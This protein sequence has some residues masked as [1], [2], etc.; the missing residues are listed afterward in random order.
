[1]RIHQWYKNLVIYL[2]LI[3]SNSLFNKELF[4][5]TTLGLI[6]LCLISST[7][8]IINDIL[9]RKKDKEHQ[10]KKTRPIAYGSIKIYEAIIIALIIT[11]ISLFIA[12]NLSKIFLLSVIF[13]LVLTLL[14]SFKLKHIL[15]LDIIIIS[16]NF[17]IRSVSGTFIINKPLSPWLILCPFFLA[18]FLAVGKRHGDL[19]LLGKNAVNHKQVLKN[20]TPE[21]NGILII[22]STTLLL[23]SY[24][25]YAFL[26]EHKKLLLTIPF[27]I[28]VIFRY[29]YLIY[30]ESKIARKPNLLYKDK[31]LLIGL[32]LWLLVTFMLLYFNFSTYQIIYPSQSV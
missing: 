14:Y 5:A 21:I 18:L 6:S 20:Y 19:R 13:L 22:I 17:V 12:Y 11:I 28:Y 30:S 23:I 1:M 8:Y 31:E 2:A 7:N 3:F 29:V 32:L 24:S 25:L 15:F 4:I 10:E 27:A 9:D 26:G 16:I